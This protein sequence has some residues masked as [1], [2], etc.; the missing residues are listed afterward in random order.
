MIPNSDLI[1]PIL[2]WLEGVASGKIVELGRSE[3]M[4]GRGISWG[5]FV[6][7]VG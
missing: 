4:L 2:A 1:L 5:K 3:Y 6:E 7:R